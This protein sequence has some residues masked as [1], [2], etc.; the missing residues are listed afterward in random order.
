MLQIRR[1]NERGHANHGW[2]DTNHSF[3]FGQYRDPK[4]M[5]F[6]VL[7]VINE[8]RVQAGH[9]FGTHP[10]SDMEILSYVRAGEL[11][12]KDS[13]GNGSVIKPGEFQLI[14]AGSGITHSEFNPSSKQETHFYQIWITP[15]AKGLE[16]SYQQ[17]SFSNIKQ[18]NGLRIIA[19]LSGENGSLKINQD[20]KIYSAKLKSEES[21]VL[22]LT[23]QRHG[24]LQVIEGQC[25]LGEDLLNTSDGVSFSNEL[26]PILTAQTDCELLFFDLP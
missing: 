9:G 10:H 4:H 3:S 21:L 13:M 6:R 1:A 23:A 22:P 26:E 5:G 7:R 25:Q 19:S 14:S 11:E 15:N 12:H 16:P 8:D 18:G 17:A 2:L 24:W 20:V